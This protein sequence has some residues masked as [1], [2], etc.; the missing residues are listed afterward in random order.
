MW[1]K[2]EQTFPAVWGLKRAFFFLYFS[3][4]AFLVLYVFFSFFLLIVDRENQSMLITWVT[5]FI[6]FAWL[7]FY[8]LW[9][10]ALKYIH[11][12]NSRWTLCKQNSAQQGIYLQIIIIIIIIFIIVAI[13]PM[14][15]YGRRVASLTN[16]FHIAWKLNRYSIMCSMSWAST[17]GG[18][19]LSLDQ[20]TAEVLQIDGLAR[21][22]ACDRW[23]HRQN[24]SPR[25]LISI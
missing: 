9:M 5:I 3:L 24:P 15:M 10:T 25:P 23:F 22:R 13:S 8:G 16:S 21:S 12:I 11:Y 4:F 18:T 19:H 17:T 2:F 6:L 14:T 20:T 7:H 1:W